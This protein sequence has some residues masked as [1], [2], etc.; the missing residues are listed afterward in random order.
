MSVIIVI[1]VGLGILLGYFFVPEYFSTYISKIITIG[2]GFLIF[3]AGI[4]LGFTKGLLKKIKKIGFKILI[5]PL[6]AI[7]GSLAGASFISLFTDI[8]LKDAL[9]VGSG[10]G[11]STLAP[12]LVMDYSVKLSAIAFLSNILRELIGIAIVPIVASRLGYIEAASLPGASS[13][14]LS[15]PVIERYCSSQGAIYSIIIGAAMTVT[16]P[17]LIP[18]IIA[19]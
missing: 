1:C 8:T 11:W 18:F 2:L 10:L 7:L 14:D 5:F 12:V 19:I 15:L 9:I 16:V 6:M 4:D 13:M 3:N 17:I